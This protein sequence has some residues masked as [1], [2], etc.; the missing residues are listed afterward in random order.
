[1][2]EG[3]LNSQQV[4]LLNL[5][6]NISFERNKKIRWNLSQQSSPVDKLF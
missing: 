1:M 6:L 5:V 3:S 4:E 2:T